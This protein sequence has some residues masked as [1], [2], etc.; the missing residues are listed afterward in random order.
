MFSSGSVDLSHAGRCLVAKVKKFP[1][2]E[3]GPTQ[4]QQSQAFSQPTLPQHREPHQP[5]VPCS[6]AVLKSSER[7]S[8]TN[9]S[10]AVVVLSSYGQSNLHYAKIL[11]DFPKSTTVINRLHSSMSSMYLSPRSSQTTP[12]AEAPV[13][14]NTC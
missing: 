10:N 8:S 12:D 4:L 7:L 11:P 3:R 1:E 9:K 2:G 6:P 13:L 5:P 14:L